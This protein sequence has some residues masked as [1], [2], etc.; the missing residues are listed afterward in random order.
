MECLP[1]PVGVRGRVEVGGQCVDQRLRHD[2]L[3]WAEVDLINQERKLRGTDLVRPDHRR[4]D[5]Y[6]GTDPQD[7]QL[8]ALA[9]G[10]LDQRDPPRPLERVT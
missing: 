9:K 2:H 7:R 6:P 10:D 3:L 8:F 4:Q 1:V 5:E